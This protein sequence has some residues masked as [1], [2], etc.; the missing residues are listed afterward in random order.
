MTLFRSLA[1]L[2]FRE[3]AKNRP[4]ESRDADP[5]RTNRLA[6]D[7]PRTDHRNRVDGPPAQRWHST[8]RGRLPLLRR[9]RRQAQPDQQRA[10][11]SQCKKTAATP[12]VGTEEIG[13]AS[14]REGGWQYVE[15]SVVAVTLKK[16]HEKNKEE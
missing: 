10:G 2:P 6:S 7:A 8:G 3:L 5:Q 15:I 13:R 1:G 9:N 14:C 16:K 4:A 11:A 12:T